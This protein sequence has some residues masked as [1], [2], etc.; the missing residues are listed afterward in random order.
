[1]YSRS[2]DFRIFLKM[3]VIVTALA[4]TPAILIA[5]SELSDNFVPGFVI[6]LCLYFAFF[7]KKKEDEKC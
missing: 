6:G 2:F 7:R 5:G 1:M 3:L 4:M